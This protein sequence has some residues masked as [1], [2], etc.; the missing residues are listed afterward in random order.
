MKRICL[1]VAAAVLCG[2]H[3]YQRLMPGPPTASEGSSVVPVET[4]R[5]SLP[6]EPI[7]VGTPAGEEAEEPTA[8][9]AGAPR[10]T[11]AQAVETINGQLEDAFFGYDHF[12]LSPEAVTALR[13]DAALLRDIL[14][15]FPALRIIVQ[16][17]CDE[18]GSAEYNLALGDR[19]ATIAA[20]FL[21]QLGLPDSAIAPVS[22]GKEAPQCIEGN[23]SC[24]RL[25]RRAHLVVRPPVTE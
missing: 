5:T 15:D 23:E 11:L 21:R 2:C 9:A 24:W 8:P 19:R 14:R 25:N 6:A 22:Y 1:L 3:R 7:A 13:R 10:P 16:G 17:H 18:R 20:D 12:D 4:R